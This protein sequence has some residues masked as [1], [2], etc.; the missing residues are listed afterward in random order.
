MKFRGRNP[1]EYRITR[2]SADMWSF[3]TIWLCTLFSVSYGQLAA[4]RAAAG[5]YL[6]STGDLSAAGPLITLFQFHNEVAL[7]ASHATILL[8]LAMVLAVL[9]PEYRPALCGASVAG[10]L[11]VAFGYL[12]KIVH[13]NWERTNDLFLQAK[14]IEQAQGLAHVTSWWPDISVTESAGPMLLA[15]LAFLIATAAWSYFGLAVV[16]RERRGASERLAPIAAGEALRPAD[17]TE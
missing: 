8:A 2:A 17:R 1:E 4:N 12:E 13:M 6:S 10:T 7:Y 3:F 14:T 11:L 16:A 5:Y 9:K 15:D